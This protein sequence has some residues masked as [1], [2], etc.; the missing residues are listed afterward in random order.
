MDYLYTILDAIYYSPPECRV[1]LLLLIVTGYGVTLLL[2]VL[3]LLKKSD[4][5]VHDIRS[6]LYGGVKCEDC[7]KP[8]HEPQHTINGAKT[9]CVE[10][11][12]AYVKCKGCGGDVFG[13]YVNHKGL[14]SDCT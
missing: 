2:G 11:Y 7:N 8:T 5:E 3:S 1:G 14:C 4:G 12:K 6:I 13:S 10:C 9:V